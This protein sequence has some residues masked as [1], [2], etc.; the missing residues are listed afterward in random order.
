MDFEK[1]QKIIDDIV[2]FIKSVIEKMKEF[3]ADV[4]EM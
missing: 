2:G 1:L 4:D 3:L